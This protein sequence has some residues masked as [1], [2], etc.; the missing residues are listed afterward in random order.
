MQ[1]I[2]LE[3]ALRKEK[4]KGPARR[5]RRGGRIPGV[6]Y[7]RGKDTYS[8]SL[9]PED[10]KKIL[11]SGARENT[12]IALKVM[13][14]GAEKIGN[15]VVMLKDL[16]ADPILRTYLHADFYIVA[17]DEKIEV[18]IPIRLTGKA[19]GVK[20]GGIV[21]QPRREIRVRCLPSNIPE[22]IEV[23]VSSL[24]IGDSIHVQDIPSSAQ[25]EILAEGNFSIASVTP[26]I[27][28]A[29]YEE[30]VAAPEVEREI[31][32]P[33]RIGEKAEPEEAQEAKGSKGGSKE[34]KEPKESKE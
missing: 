19:E 29:K 17:M 25:Y 16:Q 20:L 23:D 9:K 22:F 10:L 8:L 30:M 6:L 13:G 4:G 1:E 18:E 5:M 27:S 21:E 24:N 28:E 26:P 32:Q 12:L 15:Q 34:A 2:E 33:E 31:A 11:S 7:G 3:V 14:E